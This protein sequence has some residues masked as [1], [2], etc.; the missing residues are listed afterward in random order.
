MAKHIKITIET[1]SLLVLQ[2][3]YS[4]RAWCPLCAAESEMIALENAG[5]ISNLQ[6]PALEQWLKSGDLHR[7]PTRLGAPT[8][9]AKARLTIVEPDSWAGAPTKRAPGAQFR[10]KPEFKVIEKNGRG[11]RI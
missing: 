2:G 11:E 9:D 5:L 3:H 8:I 1:N 6:P 7:L 10:G 4:R